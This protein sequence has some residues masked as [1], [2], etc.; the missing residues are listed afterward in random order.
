ML[1]S[2]FSPP[3]PFGCSD[4]TVAVGAE[5]YQIDTDTAAA[6]TTTTASES[7]AKSTGVIELAKDTAATPTTVVTVVPVQHGGTSH[8]T[9]SIRFLGKAGWA[10]RKSA[11]KQATTET[12]DQNIYQQLAS[13]QLVPDD[14]SWD[15]M[16]G[17]PPVLEDE[18]E[19]LVM[20]GAS[21]AP[22][23]LKPSSGAIFG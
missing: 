8:R 1:Y 6:A 14:P 3:N 2:H 5:L 21:G 4:D 12:V 18:I 23:L 9:P 15:P 11:I 17:R 7:S 19:S 20:G 16:Y 22:K 10:A 13:V